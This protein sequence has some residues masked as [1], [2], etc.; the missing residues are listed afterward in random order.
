MLIFFFTIKRFFE[1]VLEKFL[2]KRTENVT[3]NS[4]EN[5]EF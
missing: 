1:N 5:E 2:N 4:D 3:I